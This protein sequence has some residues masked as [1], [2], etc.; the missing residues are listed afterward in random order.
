MIHS[1]PL[2]Y[3]PAPTAGSLSG[4]K[5]GPHL[6]VHQVHRSHYGVL[7]AAV[8]EAS[9]EAAWVRRL[10][11]AACADPAWRQAVLEASHASETH[12]LL[13]PSRPV[14]ESEEGVSL[15]S[16]LDVGL[17]LAM[18]MRL[19][20]THKPPVDAKHA[21][22]LAL[23]LAEATAHLHGVDGYVAGALTPASV[24]VH[25]DGTA[26][27]IDALVLHRVFENEALASHVDH[28]AYRAPEQ[29]EA[30]AEVA[31]HADVFSV[32]VMLYEL[33]ARE[34]LFV[35]LDAAGVRERVASHAPQLG[36]LK[37]PD[38][39][40]QV[41]LQCL[42]KRPERRF[43]DAAALQAALASCDE[44]AER[45]ELA[46][47]VT[48]LIGSHPT[49]RRMREALSSG[50]SG[51]AEG[52]SVI[53]AKLA[54]AAHVRP[55][56]GPP[57]KRTELGG[58]AALRPPP[59]G[60]K[61]LP[62]PPPRPSSPSQD[63]PPRPPVLEPADLLSE[64]P[65]APAAVSGAPS[66][67]PREDDATRRESSVR[68][69]ASKPVA[70]VEEFD[71]AD[72]PTR[73]VS[74][75]KLIEDAEELVREAEEV[76]AALAREVARSPQGSIPPADS[77]PPPRRDEIQGKR[78][79]RC[80]LGPEIARGG[81]ATVHLGR[82][83]GAGGFAKTVAVKRLH[84]QYATDPEFVHML[85]DEARVV[86]RIRHPNVTSTIDVLDSEGELFIVMDYVHGVTL[87]HLLRQMKRSGEQVPVRIATRIVNGMLHGLYAAHEATDES[88]TRLELIHRDV[89][90]ENV[91]IGV[92]GYSHLIDFG[93]A[94]ALGRHS[95]SVDGQ[96]KGKLRYLSPE[97]VM[98]EELDGQ[99]DVFSAAIVLWECLLRKRLFKG[100]NAGAIA[101]E[102]MNREP[103]P[104]SM[105][106]PDVSPTID[107]IVL[108]GL[109]NA[110]SERWL[111]A[112]DMAEAL[113]EAGGMAS[114]REVGEWVRKV[115]AAQL[116]RLSEAV[117]DVESMPAEIAEAELGL[118][119]TVT[120]SIA[121][122][123]PRQPLMSAELSVDDIPSGVNVLPQAAPKRRGLFVGV[124]VAAAIAIVAAVA[125]RG[126]EETT[127][128]REDASHA[129]PPPLPAPAATETSSP[130]PTPEP[131]PEPSSVA[132]SAPSA[133]P[134]S[135]G[136]VG[137]QPPSQWPLPKVGP[138]PPP[139]PRLPDGI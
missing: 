110:K 8:H 139:N 134:V 2:S 56:L 1:F 79:G 105:L 81:M 58:A 12:P 5:I 117:K 118:P 25:M 31:G 60:S 61:G 88:G 90:P 101:Y 86:S 92:D 128:G 77:I 67:P 82:W 122:P 131:V 111:T 75:D 44:I 63:L 19:W 51:T 113:E 26:K 104:P 136:P 39:A 37:L 64:P 55:P 33:L 121:M 27:V 138:K 20:M 50:G 17:P 53:R 132:S 54:P 100:E 7:H 29:L 98:G 22:R 66:E 34:R 89:S 119:L 96:V 46:A 9:G 78:L 43:A 91:I 74:P 70:P 80:V 133:A 108:R 112:A 30:D 42:A 41:L 97:Q 28:L 127:A 69:A 11:S 47:L 24:I 10:P 36:K 115:G 137:P 35:A 45:G 85:L 48:Q 21:L 106:R 59:P 83:H 94:R 3:S 13:V 18:L 129:A 116:D 52:K 23:D 107:R 32:G 14:V 16:E 126:G 114:F 68:D 71:I 135:S 76:E 49:M 120:A 72:E 15:V 62:A 73:A 38:D 87:A 40:R 103:T 93:I 84:P 99:S 65:E 123:P 130:E 109:K 4:S 95:H 6:L 102:I 125:L 124:G 57:P